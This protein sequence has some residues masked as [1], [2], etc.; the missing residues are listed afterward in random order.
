MSKRAKFKKILLFF[1]TINFELRR[2]IM[3]QMKSLR[4]SSIPP[5]RAIETFHYPGYVIQLKK[6]EGQIQAKRKNLHEKICKKKLVRK[7]CPSQ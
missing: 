5:E 3:L 1:K 2:N 7:R 6:R 4:D